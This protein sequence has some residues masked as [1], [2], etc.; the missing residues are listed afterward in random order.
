MNKL[1]ERKIFLFLFLIVMSCGQIK[2]IKEE[3]VGEEENVFGSKDY[4]E[5][6]VADFSAR[7]FKQPQRFSLQS[8]DALNLKHFFFDVNP[9]IN[10]DK[11]TLKFVISTPENSPYNY[12]IDLFSGQHYMN[13]KYCPMRDA[14]DL[15][16]EDIER[17]PF[18]IGIVPRVFDQLG[19]PQ[20]VLVVG[21]EKYFQEYFRT[22]YFDGRVLGGYIEQVCSKGAC[23]ERKQWDS[24]LVLVAV[25]NK[26]KEFRDIKNLAELKEK[27]KWKKFRAFVENGFGQNK[28]AQKYYPA[29]KMGPLID[30]STAMSFMRQN[31]IFFTVKK[32]TKMR[33]SCYK[34]YDFLWKYLGRETKLEKM[35]KKAKT[36]R[37]LAKIEKKI[38]DDSDSIFLKRFIKA[39]RKYQDEF[40]TCTKYIYYGNYQNDKDHFWFMTH[41]KMVSLAHEAGYTYSCKRG[42]WVRNPIGTDGKRI[43]TVKREFKGC[44]SRELDN[45]FVQVPNLFKNLKRNNAQSYRFV[46]YDRGAYGLHTK[47]Y[48]WVPVSG[49][50]YQCSKNKEYYVEQNVYPSDIRWKK[51][52]IKKLEKMRLFY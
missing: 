46:D 11:K 15:F 42:V 37:Q 13:H 33:N 38:R 25:Q 20:K 14:W 32:L 51:R 1:L 47:L 4:A 5:S 27:I 35:A 29:V 36:K 6:F 3:V 17:P 23:L 50:R 2:E 49:K 48:S 8:D 18:S 52:H 10:M 28:I 45:A 7:W 22:N 24:R 44:S 9:D 43:I 12:Q 19:G 30:A 21:D 34:L 39:F 26:N 16:K 31:S 40:K 41:L